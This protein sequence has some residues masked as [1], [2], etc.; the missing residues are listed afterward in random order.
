MKDVLKKIARPLFFAFKKRLPLKTIVIDSVG[1]KNP[2]IIA[3][4]HPEYRGVRS[5]T[6][7]M[8]GDLFEVSAIHT[9]EKAREIARQIVKY[10]PEKV[11]ISGYAIG[12]DLLASEIK[13]VAPNVRI[14]AFIHS[15]FIWFDVY[16]AENYV[17]EAFVDMA[18]TGIIEKIGFCKRDLAEFFKT[19]GVDSY[20]V[21]NRFY[22]EKHTFRELSKEKIKIGIFGKNMWHRNITNQ[23]L[24]ALGIENAEVHVNEV[25]NHFF[26]D[27]NRVIVH[28]ILPKDEF[29]K[30]YQTLDINMYISLTECFPMSVI[31]SM[32]YG[33]PCLVSDTSDV[34]TWN[35]KLKKLLTVSTIDSPLGITKKIQEVV[36]NYK[37][38]Q[39]EI[40]GYLPI[41]KTKVENS[42][43]EFL[44]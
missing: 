8:V 28:G 6:K 12:Y 43:E 13:N 33:I 35:E 11:L 29:L 4:V 25:S 44:R 26:I 5:A 14:F 19:Q 23:V 36:A 3:V 34:Y 27:K 22:P 1:S 30:L 18:K 32:Q 38:I 7:E 21:M 41:L 31:E 42:I 15:A 37:E 24:G 40:E 17:F 2:K 39:K 9:R 16:P 10:N 20:F